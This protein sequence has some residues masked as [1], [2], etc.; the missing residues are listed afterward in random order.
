MPARCF[1]LAPLPLILSACTPNDPAA[2]AARDA[3]AIAAAP[4]AKVVGPA[5]NCI[6]RSQ[7]RATVVRSDRVI[8]FEMNGGKVYRS[9]LPNRCIGLTFDRAIIYETSIDQLCTQQIVYSLQNIGG[10]PQ[11][12]AG[13]SLGEFVPV[14]YVKQT[15]AES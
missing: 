12:G 13:C 14:E 7:V 2:D 5:Q 11:R 4:E 9:T 3:A 6:N 15:K 1:A 10:V 8:D